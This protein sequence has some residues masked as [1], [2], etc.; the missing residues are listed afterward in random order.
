MSVLPPALAAQWR[1]LPADGEIDFDQLQARELA[2]QRAVEAQAPVAGRAAAGAPAA[3]GAI[4]RAHWRPAS[5]SVICTTSSVSGSWSR[6]VAARRRALSTWPRRSTKSSRA[7]IVSRRW[8]ACPQATSTA[9]IAKA[10][11]YS[12]SCSARP[13]A[14]AGRRPDAVDRRQRDEPAA[15]RRAGRRRRS[16]SD[17][18]SCAAAGSVAIVRGPC[19]A[20][21]TDSPPATA[22]WRSP[23]RPRSACRRPRWLAGVQWMTTWSCPRC[24][25]RPPKRAR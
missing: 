20:T 9:W 24:P 10:A 25:V 23:I 14:A 4:A 3:V 11:G 13:G 21:S 15:A 2:L 8:R 22:R 18:G 12:S 16:L 7:R 6:I 19:A 5:S 1:T 17:R